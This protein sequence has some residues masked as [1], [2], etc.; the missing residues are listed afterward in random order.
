MGGCCSS[1]S[2]QGNTE[3]N[4]LDRNKRQ[5]Q[6]NWTTTGTI[7]LRDGNLKA[8][9]SAALEVGPAAR[10][11]DLTNNHLTYLPDQISSFT[12]LS[13]LILASNQLNALPPCLSTLTSLKVLVLD[14]NQLTSLPTDIG[15]LARLEKLSVKNNAL[16][17]LPVSIKQ[18]EKL[19]VL[20]LSANSL[21][22]LTA[23]VA[24]CAQ[25]EELNVSNNDLQ[26][27]PSSLQQLQ[28]VKILNF[29]QNRITSVPSGILTGCQALHTLLLHSNPISAQSFEA[30][31]GYQEFE[32]RRRTKYNKNITTGVSMG[33]GLQEGVDRQLK[34]V[35]H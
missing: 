35:Q 18:L 25:L 29:S 32:Q 17:T 14:S 11:L 8:L 16:V 10:V 6:S 21:S 31:A 9:P 13:R 2:Q 7:A 4:N 12:N 1:Q 34:P 19:S 23:A 15:Q 33:N 24:G 28:K 22:E 26:A 30:T 5:R 27:I 3:K 20:D